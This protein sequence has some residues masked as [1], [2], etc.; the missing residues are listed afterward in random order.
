M[1]NK[2]RSFKLDLILFCVIIVII[3]FILQIG[4]F[5]Y[6]TRFIIV[7]KSNSYFQ[8]T[9][10]QVGKRIELQLTQCEKS[11][12]I[13]DNQALK[14]YLTSLRNGDINYYIAKYKI[15]REVL[16]PLDYDTIESIYI[17][18]SQYP[19]INCYYSI[20]AFEMNS[21]E[22][23]LLSDDSK[24]IL[25]KFHWNAVQKEPYQIPVYFC[26][27]DESERV[28]LLN[29]NFNETIL[30][31]VMDEVK[32]GEKGQVY[33]VDNSNN[34]IFA[35][36]RSL[37]TKQFIPPKGKSESIVSY[38]LNNNGW[39]LIG[40]VP[41][42]EISDQIF[43]INQTFFILIILIFTVIIAFVYFAVRMVLRPLNK[44]VKGMELIQRG[45]LNIT[46]SM[47][48]DTAEY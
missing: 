17:F 48:A 29:I 28:G 32:L 23:R 38:T 14:N 25:G 47:C 2:A 9:V 1:I 39:K 37:I 35:K 8:E 22:R 46:L 10:D 19:P 7:Q 34:I 11:M 13:A 27:T 26:I 44:I 6:L 18:T 3:V 15:V 45:N 33:L 21:F 20:P 43:K 31:Q 4:V 36:D 16:R 30:K 42:T 5:Q 12:H 41:Y 40:V 24:N